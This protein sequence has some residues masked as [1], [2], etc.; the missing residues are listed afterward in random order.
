MAIVEHRANSVN[1]R[2]TL[3]NHLIVYCLDLLDLYP[4]SLQFVCAPKNIL[5]IFMTTDFE[6]IPV[7]YFDHLTN[8]IGT[9][10]SSVRIF[11]GRKW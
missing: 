4:D 3:T 5:G 9:E 11:N 8:Y 2:L 1:Y 10:N 7:E 6:Y